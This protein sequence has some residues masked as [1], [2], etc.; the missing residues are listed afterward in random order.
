M[1]AVTYS[2]VLKSLNHKKRY[3]R[4]W[5]IY[6]VTRLQV[7]SFRRD[8]FKFSFGR[9]RWVADMRGVTHEVGRRR[10]L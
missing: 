9:L 3:G 1:N 6:D 2:S 10:V 4:V 7:E 5:E 8:M